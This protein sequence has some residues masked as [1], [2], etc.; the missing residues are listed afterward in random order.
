[1]LVSCAG[2]IIQEEE[3]PVTD[4][5]HRFK[6]LPDPDG[7]PVIRF[8]GPTAVW[9]LEDPEAVAD[10]LSRL[11]DLEGGG[12]VRLDLEE[13]EFVNAAT[14]TLLRALAQ[15]LRGADRELRLVNVRPML[16]EVFEA[17]QWSE[18]FGLSELQPV[19]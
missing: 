8:P 11:P 19:A 16:A 18:P 13:V 17:A 2:R 15:R 9:S 7:G 12:A 3:P 5:R 14:F 1:M 10:E 4:S 6:L